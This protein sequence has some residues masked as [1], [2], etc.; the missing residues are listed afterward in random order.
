MCRALTF[1]QKHSEK[2]KV[3]IM[4]MTAM[5]PKKIEQHLSN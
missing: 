5:A 2:G 4:S 1:M 3:K